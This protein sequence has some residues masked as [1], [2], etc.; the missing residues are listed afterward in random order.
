MTSE[1]APTRRTTAG[2]LLIVVGLGVGVHAS[3]FA[4]SRNVQCTLRKDGPTS[5]TEVTVHAGSPAGRLT[6][7][8]TTTVLLGG[9]SSVTLSAALGKRSIIRSTFIRSG[10]DVRGTTDLGLGFKGVR[11]VELATADGGQLAGTIDGRAVTVSGTAGSVDALVFADGAPAPR[12]K[13]KRAVARALAKAKKALQNASCPGASPAPAGPGVVANA[14][15]DACDRCKL[16]CQFD[17]SK[18]GGLVCIGNAFLTAVSC[19]ASAVITPVLCVASFE[20][21]GLS[22]TNG[23]IDCE[24]LC[25]KSDDCCKVHCPGAVGLCC[26]GDGEV[27][28]GRDGPGGGTCCTSCCG[29]P[30]ERAGAVCCGVGI[31][32]E[33]RR[34]LNPDIGLCCEPDG[35]ICGGTDCCPPGWTCCNDHYCAPP[36]HECC[37][38]PSVPSSTPN[39]FCGAGQH[40]VDPKT[41]LC[42]APDAGPEC[43]SG[44]MCCNGAQLCGSDQTCCTVLDLCGSACCPSG[45][46]LNGSECCADALHVCGGHCC[47]GFQ[48]CCNGQCCSGICVGGTTCCPSINRVCGNTCCPEGY[49]CTDPTQQ[50][51]EPCPMGGEGCPA[52]SGNP[53]CCPSASQCCSSGECCAVGD[54]CC[55]D[56]PACHPGYQCIH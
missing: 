10:A 48:Q 20:L 26:N 9:D 45:V 29:S 38:D 50:R 35:T 24:Q 42:C 7:V 40:C 16:G 4:R 44:T 28:C 32:G 31:T 6:V 33:E 19:G 30:N 1:S 52:S 46:C 36:G 53:M 14:I 17:P 2:R 34:C 37:S 15:F 13:T 49:A 56:P 25:E 47:S 3:A 18:A 21:N 23:L 5:V 41:N 11:H 22:C 54:A 12:L 8:V 27:C 39:Y 43:G 55:G 51:C